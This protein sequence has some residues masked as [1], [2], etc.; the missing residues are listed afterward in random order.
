[1][2]QP[3]AADTARVP[4]RKRNGAYYTPEAVAA[5]LV[6]SAVR[7]P[8]DRLLDPACGDGRF[9]AHHANSEGVERDGQ[10]ASTACQ[11]APAARIH[12]EEFFA[13]AQR[14]ARAGEQFDCVVG[15]PPF[16]RYQTFSGDVRARA[17]AL[18]KAHG[19]SFSALSASWAPF[20]LVAA[21]LLRPGGRL[22]F[23]VPATIGH[24][25]AGGQL[26]DHLVGRF[27]EVRVV[28]VRRK[29]FPRLS[30]D[31]WLLL[32]ARYGGTTN[33][34]G[35]AA[36]DPIRPGEAM[37]RPTVRVDVAEWRSAWRRRLRPYLLGPQARTL[38]LK[39]A[40]QADGPSVPP[41]AVGS[42]STRAS[43]VRLDD[44]ATV[45][46]GYVSGANGFLHLTPSR[47]KQA[48]IPDTL[49]QTT[50][51][52]R[53]RPAAAGANR[54]HGGR[55]ASQRRSDAAAAYPQGRVRTKTSPAVSGQ[56]PRPAGP[57][58]I[59]VPPPP[60][61]VLRARRTCARLLPELHGRPRP[62]PGEKRRWRLLHQRPA[63]RTAYGCAAPSRARICLAP[64]AR[65]WR[66]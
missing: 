50:G 11:R 57:R 44:L 49:L 51:T 61:V 35:F 26:L 24:A 16:I 43:S 6:R 10:A 25:P 47:S 4:S 3:Q 13:W 18:C 20:L 23:V 63:L 19:V 42:R 15:N 1:M 39:A 7:A 53:P 64:G 14:A 54:W 34:I 41:A 32:A 56:R 48:G 38:Y 62:K 12:N 36:V 65:H 59:Q 21:S 30:E 8:S 52:Q 17:L 60:A 27:A 58:G 5:L 55:L 33:E 2:S 9:L 45:D 29:L 31:C 28:A 40:A 37:P 22:A 46:L 66:S